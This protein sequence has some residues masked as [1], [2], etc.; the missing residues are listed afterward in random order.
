VIVAITGNRAIAPAE[1]TPPPD[2]AA[3]SKCRGSGISRLAPQRQRVLDAVRALGSASPS[4]VVG[5]LGGVAT[6]TAINRAATKPVEDALREL[7]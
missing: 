6:E 1:R 5:S 4:D 2:G 7:P 3:C